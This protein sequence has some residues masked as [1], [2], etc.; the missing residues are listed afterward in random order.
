MGIFISISVASGGSLSVCSDSILISSF[1]VFFRDVCVPVCA[2]R[3]R[4]GSSR[5]SRVGDNLAPSSLFLSKRVF[6]RLAIL[7]MFSS[8]SFIILSLRT[9]SF[10]LLRN[11]KAKI[12]ATRFIKQRSKRRETSNSM[13]MNDLLCIPTLV[14]HVIERLFVLGFRFCIQD[15]FINFQRHTFAS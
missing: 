3:F 10:H 7:V 14:M 11:K 12:K 2:K 4:C 6:L 15:L 8:L 9:H 13:M 1:I 5:D